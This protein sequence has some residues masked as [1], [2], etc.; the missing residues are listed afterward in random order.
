MRSTV[1]RIAKASAAGG[2]EEREVEVHDETNRR[3][4]SITSPRR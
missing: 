4:F 2:Y 1:A 3:L